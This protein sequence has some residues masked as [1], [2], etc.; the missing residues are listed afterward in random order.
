MDVDASELS[1]VAPSLINSIVVPRPVAWA[2]TLDE[3]G[4]GNLAPFSYFNVV[5][6]NPPVVMVSFSAA[7][8]K[9][10]LTNVQRTGELVINVVSHDLRHE[11]VASSA[12]VPAEVDEI[13]ELR[14]ET[15]PSVRVRPPRLAAAAA[16]LECR[17][18]EVHPVFTSTVIFARVEHVHVA[19]EVIRDG[20]VIPE[21]LAP[22]GRLGGSS[23]STVGESYRIDRPA[24]GATEVP[25]PSPNR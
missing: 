13:A 21:L 4:V 11:M 20:R 23:Y 6:G 16:A 12:D 24:D 10:T 17:L 7:G 1:R 5:C 9:D 18:Y 2:S 15:A 25:V 14:L 22:V 8:R 3:H 19:D